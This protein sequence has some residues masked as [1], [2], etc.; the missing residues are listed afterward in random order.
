M[1]VQ[2]PPQTPAARDER[3]VVSEPTTNLYTALGA[4]RGI[5]RAVDDFLERIAADRT[6]AGYFVGVDM[7]GLRRHQVELLTAATGGP[8]V[9][10]GRQMAIA[11]AGLNITDE[12]FDRVLGHLNA[13][14]VDA[15]AD[16]GTIRA[17]L[18]VLS[19]LRTEIV[20]A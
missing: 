12:A 8:R 5:R 18:T 9:Y 15:G 11:H 7:E 19:G 20:G 3:I 14:L 17:V 1:M 10:S 2:S 16:D 4:H 13:A 6:L